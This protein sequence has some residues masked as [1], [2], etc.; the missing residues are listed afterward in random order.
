MKISLSWLKEFVTWTD[1]VEELVELLTRAGMEVESVETKGV[2]FPNVV[3]AQILESGP[4]PNADRLSVCRVDDGSGESRQIVC[5][6]KNYKVG[7]K[8]PLALPGAVLPGDFKIK[9]GKLRGVESEGMMCSAKELQLA[10]DADGLLILPSDVTV[11]T[12][13]SDV[14]PPETVLGIEITSNRP[15]WLSHAGLAR[16]IA[17]NDH[18]EVSLPKIDVPAA[19]V[20][21][22]VARIEDLAGCPFYSLRVVRGVR[23]GPSPEWLRRRLEAIGL[24][25]INN[26]VDITNLV[27]ME[28]GQPLHAF[29][30]A[31][32]EGGIV[33]RRASANEKFLALDGRE[34][35]LSAEDLVIS[36]SGS[37]VA[38]AGVMGGEDSGV[39]ESTT[40]VLLESAYFDAPCVRYTA[41]R[42]ELQ[43]DSSYRFERGVDPAGVL[44]AGA[45]A[46]QLI[47][48]LAG[49]VADDAVVTAGTLPATE[50]TV[51]L[52]YDRCRMLLGVDFSPEEID[53]AL[54]KLGLSKLSGDDAVSEWKVPSAR[55]DL[56][57]EVDLIEEVIRIVG[58]DRVAGRIS[59]SPASSS[60]ADVAYDEAMALRQTL[61][62]LGFSEA[63]TSTLVAR[64][65]TG[66]ERFR[67]LRNPLGDEQSTL[68][69]SLMPGLL[70]AVQRNLALGVETVRLFEMGRTF[71]AIGEEEVP[72]VALVVTGPRDRRTWR[73]GASR[74]LDLFDLKGLV[75]DLAPEVVFSPTTN[76]AFA[77][78]LE[79]FVGGFV[80]GVIG[81]L[82]PAAARELRARGPVAVAEIRA[83]LLQAARQVRMFT[84]IS[85]FPAVTRDFAAVIPRG[86]PYAELRQT[87]TDANEPLL[88]GVEPFDVFTD[89][90]GA[91]MPADRKSLAFS[92]TF[93]STGRT[94]TAEEVNASC[95]R[96]KSR[97]REKIAAEF[98]E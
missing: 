13:I 53:D 3:V 68:R 10:E 77:L 66:N 42:H 14:F 98:R 32:V 5:G 93:Q 45:R 67:I 35:S 34:Y 38:L 82:S 46:A 92:L 16:E 78:A 74:P 19:R 33:V 72:H 86:L 56:T 90:T 64:P 55:G 60:M 2:D 30:A 84:P 88:V 29:D 83:D 12:P 36:D 25:P 97:L 57:R 8:V 40:D 1:T 41:R 76:P 47:M 22:S 23:V 87:I 43:S 73:S 91:R 7:D 59:G 39:T 69:N 17:A 27:M 65:A 31:K 61:R 26:V 6:A 52:R 94:L 18:A 79:I 96:L 89:D 71:S 58:I 50:W 62:G 63:R 24:R 95:D 70:D 28:L 75:E 15:D 9:V 4:H 49:G 54:S 81:Q 21:D 37:P 20:D 51:S 48:E 85:K 44:P 80:A 11:G